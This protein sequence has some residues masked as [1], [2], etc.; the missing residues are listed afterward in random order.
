MKNRK[1]LEKAITAIKKRIIKAQAAIAKSER[2]LS[3]ATA[4]E[5]MVSLDE[6]MAALQLELNA[7]ALVLRES[8]YA[9]VRKSIEML[10][11]K[12]LVISEKIKKVQKGPSEEAMKEYLGQQRKL[13]AILCEE[14]DRNSVAL[15]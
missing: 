5:C 13:L 12:A 6:R 8:D 10:R 2:E 14:L 9:P 1:S 3:N 15:A 4:R 11:K 7:Y